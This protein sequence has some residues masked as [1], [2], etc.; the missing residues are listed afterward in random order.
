LVESVMGGMRRGGVDAALGDPLAP[1]LYQ[2]TSRLLQLDFGGAD[3]PLL[4]AGLPS[5]L[6]TETSVAKP[7]PW[8][9]QPL[10]T[11]DRLDAPSLERMGRAVLG[12]V[13]GMKEVSRAGSTSM[14]WFFG[15]GRLLEPS[16]LAVTAAIS[17]LPLLLAGLRAGG[18][19]L[20]VR[21][22]HAVVFGVAVL[23]I[24][25]LALFLLGVPNVVAILGGFR[26]RLIGLLPTGL[27]L[28][29]GALAARQGLVH[30]LL[31]GLLDLTLLLLGLAFAFVPSASPP[32][33]RRGA[34]KAQGKGKRKGLPKR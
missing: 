31:P 9:G 25:V 15:L 6:L 26:W 27:C 32:A 4:Q 17:I 24:P 21:L 30:G 19:A 7:Y 5:V 22:V 11:P 16:V 12:A 28:V 1:W 29:F 14:E 33:K 23:R 20:G 2:P 10:D 13:E 18:M 3:R 34:S 8:L